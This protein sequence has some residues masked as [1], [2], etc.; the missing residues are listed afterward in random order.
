MKL[1]S[2]AASASIY[3]ALGVVPFSLAQRSEAS[4]SSCVPLSEKPAHERRFTHRKR[5]TNGS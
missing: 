1:C 2:K 5:T 3:M 4:A